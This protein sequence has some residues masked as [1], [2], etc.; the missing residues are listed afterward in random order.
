MLSIDI[1]SGISRCGCPGLDPCI[2]K[3]RQGC[4]SWEREPGIDDDDWEPVCL[5]NRPEVPMPAPAPRTRGRDGWWTEP[6]RPKRA[7]PP[8]PASSQPS[9]AQMRAAF[10]DFFDY[11]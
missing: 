5:T 7:T 2:V 11:D 8:P 4:G 10:G 3:A 1:N 6:R 9:P